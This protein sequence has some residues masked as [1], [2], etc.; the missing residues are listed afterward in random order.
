MASIDPETRTAPGDGLG[1]TVVVLCPGDF[2]VTAAD[3]ATCLASLAEQTLRRDVFEVVVVLGADTRDVR[4][5]LDLARGRYPDLGL[6]IV[7]GVQPR[8]AAV[9]RAGIAAARGAYMTFVNVKDT[10]GPRF[11]EALFA[12]AVPDAVVLAGASTG[13]AIPG[14]AGAITGPV[15]SA[16]AVPAALASDAAKLIPTPWV[17]LAAHDR[18]A[19]SVHKTSA[20]F[21]AWLFARHAFSVHVCDEPAA[22]Y[23]S[24]SGLSR[25]TQTSDT[26]AFDDEVTSRIAVIEQLEAVVADTHDAT[27]PVLD[28]WIATETSAMG[29]YLARHPTQRPRFVDALDRSDVFHLSSSRLNS[30]VATGLAVSYCFPPYVDTSAIVAAK[31]IRQR[32]EIVDV[33]Y[34]AMDRIRDTDVVTRRI[35]DPFI[36]D[37]AAISSPSAFSSWVSIDGFR[38]LGMEQI[39]AWERIKGTY[40]TLYSRAQFAASHFLAAAYKLHHPAVQ[41]TAEFSDPLSRDVE[42]RERGAPIEE[43]PFLDRLR[44]AFRERGMQPPESHNTFLWCEWIAYVLADELLFTNPNQLE[45]M[46]RYCPEPVVA[47]VE[48]KAV[49]APHPTLPAHFYRM[50]AGDYPLDKGM[51]NLA[52]FGNFYVTRGLDDV[53]LAIAGLP[54]QLREQLQLHVFTSKPDLL[55]KRTQELDITGNVVARSYVGFL[56]FLRLTTMFDCLVVNDA[57]TAADIKNPYLPSKWSDYRGSGSP[58]WGLIEEGSPLSSQPLTYRSPVGLVSAAQQILVTLIAAK[59]GRR[60]LLEPEY[61]DAASL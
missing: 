47:M 35:A 55:H 1:I 12:A 56:D 41:W 52:Y 22:T 58:V 20:T 38:Q 27:R 16:E 44:T 32:G 6:R 42:G 59:T 48:S 10:V 29:A 30:A 15:L 46:M 26:Q 14:L 54:A 37:Q 40:R 28:A 2:D 50:V 23:R 36:C 33:V 34:N 43:G 17:K 31:R 49:V 57:V 18:R 60:T 4:A 53:L 24:G 21:W 5:E 51:I 8:P 13:P 25:Q 9:R 11:L 3:V 39:V 61:V 45:Y 19:D 7:A